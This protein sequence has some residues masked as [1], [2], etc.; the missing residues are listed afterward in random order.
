VTRPTSRG[1]RLRQSLGAVLAAAVVGLVAAPMAAAANPAWTVVSSLAPNLDDY[2]SISC[3]TAAVC[4][5]VGTS[6]FGGSSILGTHAV[7]G[8]WSTLYTAAPGTSIARVVATSPSTV[9]AL[10]V[11]TSSTDLLSSTDGGV[12]WSVEAVPDGGGVTIADVWCSG[13]TA[14]VVAVQ[15]HPRH[16]EVA[17]TT[18]LGKSWTSHQA[19]VPGPFDGDLACVAISACLTGIRTAAGSNYQLYRTTDAGGA[20]TL[21]TGVY[22]PGGPIAIACTTLHRCVASAGG[23]TSP[24]FVYASTSAGTHWTQVEK[25]AAWVANSLACTASGVCT[26]AL[27]PVALAGQA[28]SVAISS[29]A[30][31]TWTTRTFGSPSTFLEGADCATASSCVAGASEYASSPG[32]STA[33]LYATTDGGKAWT[34]V[35]GQSGP[36]SLDAVECG[37]ASSCMIVGATATRAYVETSSDAGASWTPT[38]SISGAGLALDSLSC[39]TAT[40]CLALSGTTTGGE[41]VRTTNDGAS[42]HDVTPPKSS[43]FDLFVTCVSATTCFMATETALY[44]SGNLGST[45][46]LATLPS[47]IASEITVE[48]VACATT[49]RCF[50][51]ATFEFLPIILSSTNGGRTWGIGHKITGSDFWFSDEMACASSTRCVSMAETQ[52]LFSSGF[53]E[54]PL[55]YAYAN[56]TWA[57]RYEFGEQVYAVVGLSCQSSGTCEAAADVSNGP[58]VALTSSDGGLTWTSQSLPLQVAY[59]MTCR[60]SSSCVA[61]GLDAAGGWTIAHLG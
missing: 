11:S 41:V 5:A 27:A 22:W 61:V 16:L 60:S 39:V 20:W 8:S 33:A 31:S 4:D 48:S 46:T 1:R 29:D 18:S 38:G 23:K 49:T 32:G 56:S 17:S 26:A 50:A 9:V 30:G 19:V 42:W 37:S 59:A 58:A 24:G 45:W 36:E 53:A 34:S 13:P 10:L 57:P 12:H 54:A 25:G 7:G 6:Y 55:E 21:A 43:N 47:A 14:C 2:P 44:V 51:V 40:T 28:P 3:S 15:A 35:H 52:N